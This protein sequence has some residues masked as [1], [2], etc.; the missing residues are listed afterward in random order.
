MEIN[1]DAYEVVI[2]LE[3][4]T[5]L[6]TKT[7]AFSS[8]PAEYGAMPNTLVS[9]VSLGHPGTLPRHNK[10]AVNMAMK[11]GLACKCDIN[12]YCLYARKNY[13]YA[14]LPKGYQITQD[15]TPLCSG[16]R[17]NVTLSDG[18]QKSI[19]LTR[20]HL[21]E[22]SGKSIH[23]MDLYDSLIDY[24][25]AG[26]SLIE[27]VTEPVIRSG[28]EAGLFV[29]EIRKLVRYLEVC[30]GNMEEGSLRC[31]ANISVRK[32]GSTTFGTKVEVK[33]MNSIS[34]VR[35]AIEFETKRQIEAV[36][37]GEIIKQET[38]TYDAVR[39]ITFSMR[40]KELV[41]DYRY[42]PEPDLP[43][44]VIS[45]E[46]LEGIRSSMPELPE[47][48]LYRLVND[49]SLSQYD[50]TVL[51]ETKEMAAHY[52]EVAKH[53]KNYKAAANYLMG[54]VK[55]WLNKNALEWDDL[56]LT[57]QRLA[58]LIDLIDRGVVSNA[59][60]EQNILPEMLNDKSANAMDVAQKLNLIQNSDE[61]FLLGIVVEALA[62]YPDKI[63]EYKSGKKGL[64]GLFMGEVMKLSKG[65]A[66]PKI[67]SQLLREKLEAQ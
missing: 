51:T 54:P 57:G 62:M 30:D 50:A 31:D 1:Y 19:E 52:L 64:L 17:V 36:E 41:N 58:G 27:I 11:V 55:G 10:E 28:E 49:Y 8:E 56:T 25:R 66:D 21:E 18:T 59:A 35:K 40:A 45:D 14:D 38:R 12:R 43:P 24:N 32:K 65:K 46:W 67:A 29:S 4:H 26:T 37:T 34:N 39:G 2:G 47:E 53:T 60:A 63:E 48:L 42:F 9:V 20:I 3:I 15:K 44:L 5:Q 16:G 22:D 7:K 33:N 61:D 13:F 23:D 6:L